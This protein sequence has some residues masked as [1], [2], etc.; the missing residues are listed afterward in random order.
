M[1]IAYIEKT[2]RAS[3]Q[4]M[5]ERADRIMQEYA[6]DGYDLTL[7]QLYYQFVSRDWIPNTEKSY[8]TL[9][10]LISDARLAGLLDWDV[11][12]DR[13]RELR[14]ISHWQ[15]PG[16]IVRTCAQQ[17]RLDTRA[18]QPNYI[19]VWV[20]KEALAG[21]VL[22]ACDDLDVHALIC[23]GYVSQSAMWQAARRL[24][25]RKHRDHRIIIY[26]GDHDPSGIDMTR[27]I[28]ARIAETFGTD[29]YVDRIALTLE[30]IEQYKC[31]PNPAKVTDSRFQ[32]YCDEY[33]DESWELDALE[34]RVLTRLIRD[35][36]EGHTD[37]ALRQRLLDQQQRD[38]DKLTVIADTL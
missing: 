15:N 3:S 21:I 38:R 4:D 24:G 32:A 27:D 23:R 7:R 33:G 28:Q 34:P 11:M 6:A 17:F 37:M 30:Q 20:E 35:A 25:Y 14:S 16:D 8:K 2:F 5:I 12:V 29:V 26:L 31:P 22:Q 13:T 9:G 10:N 18:D 36:V 19:E 1:K